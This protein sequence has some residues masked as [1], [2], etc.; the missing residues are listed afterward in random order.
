MPFLRAFGSYVP[1][2]VV[3]NAELAARL[4]CEAGWIAEVSGIEQRRHAA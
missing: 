2:R 4:G 3:D 1:S